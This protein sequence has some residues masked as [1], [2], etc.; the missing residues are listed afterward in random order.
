MTSRAAPSFVERNQP[1]R[2]QTGQQEFMREFTV[3][4]RTTL[5]LVESGTRHWGWRSGCCPHEYGDGIR[6]SHMATLRLY[7][8]LPC[9][10]CPNPET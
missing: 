10:S 9:D 8:L 1:S 2:A 4:C 7:N 5:P 6:P 3:A